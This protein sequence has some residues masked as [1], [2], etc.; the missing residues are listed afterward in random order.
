MTLRPLRSLRAL[1]ATALSALRFRCGALL[2]VGVKAVAQGAQRGRKGRK[3][4]FEY[5][6]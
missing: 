4:D 5:F 2:S 1:C 6:I 3:G